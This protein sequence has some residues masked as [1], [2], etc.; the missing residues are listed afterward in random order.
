MELVTKHTLLTGCDILIRDTHAIALVHGDLKLDINNF[1]GCH[2]LYLGGVG[3]GKDGKMHCV[4][5]ELDADD[6]PPADL[7]VVGGIVGMGQSDTGYGQIGFAQNTCFFAERILDM[8]DKYFPESKDVVIM[9]YEKDVF[10]L[11]KN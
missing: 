6:I 1:T 7:Q 4:T 8:L 10:R 11:T 3:R 5:F 9:K 2:T